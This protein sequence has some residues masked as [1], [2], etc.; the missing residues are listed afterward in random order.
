[1]V[2]VEEPIE[3]SLEMARMLEGLGVQYLIGG[4][5]AS[6]LHG[7]P[8]AT[9]DI[10]IVADLRPED[11]TPLVAALSGG[12]YFDEPAIRD[13]VGRRSTFNVIHLRTLFKVDVF[14]AGDDHATRR[15]LQRREVYPLKVDPPEAI[16]VASPEDTVVQKLHWYRLGDHVSD[17]QWLDALG[18]LKTRGSELD[19]EYMRDLSLQMGVA[20]LLERILGQAGLAE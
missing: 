5:L 12:Y 4:S 2:I 20:D 10:D 1:M 14:V 11:V 16:V 19:V 7:H 13:A 18:V 9:Q 3:V 6:S 8:R 17:R 15:E